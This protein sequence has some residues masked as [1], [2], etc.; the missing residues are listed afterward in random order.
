ML[1]CD[2]RQAEQDSLPNTALILADVS[3]NVA[4]ISE[5]LA[6]DDKYSSDSSSGELVDNRRVSGRLF[7]PG[8]LIDAKSLR[9]HVRGSSACSLGSGGSMPRD[10]RLCFASSGV[11]DC[12]SSFG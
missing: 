8:R 6:P 10:S 11:A 9:R 3:I 2:L 1:Q 4:Q 12:R 5:L 7:P